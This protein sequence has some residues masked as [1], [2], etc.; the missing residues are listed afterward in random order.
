MST[1]PQPLATSN[2]LSAS[3]NLLFINISGKWN[4]VLSV[5]LCLAYFT[6]HNVLKVWWLAP[7]LLVTII[8]WVHNYSKSSENIF[9]DFLLYFYRN[10]FAYNYHLKIPPLFILPWHNSWSWSSVSNVTILR[11]SHRNLMLMIILAYI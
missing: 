6:Q 5:L 11:L 2:V 9:Q 8:S 3:M 4:H 1:I 10:P 7:N